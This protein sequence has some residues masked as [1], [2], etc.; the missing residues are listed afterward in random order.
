MVR[1]VGFEPTLSRFQTAHVDQA[2]PHPDM[3][4]SDGLAPP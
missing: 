4:L 2:T 3:A 1:V